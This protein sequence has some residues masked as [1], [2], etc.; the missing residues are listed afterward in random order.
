MWKAGE[1]STK[2]RNQR[3][4]GNQFLT[5]QTFRLPLLNLT[6]QTGI[7]NLARTEIKLTNF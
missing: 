4:Q 2:N 6:V 7:N 5:F 3:Y 1:R